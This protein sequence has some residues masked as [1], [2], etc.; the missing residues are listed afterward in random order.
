MKTFKT[1][2]L[3]LLLTLSV[4]ISVLSGSV[5]AEDSTQEALSTSALEG[6][7]ILFLGDSLQTAHGLG[8]YSLSWNGMLESLDGM[9]ATNIAV[10]GSTM[11]E[12]SEGGYAW[13]SGYCHCPISARSLP[14]G[15]FDVVLIDGGANDW[16]NGLPLGSDPVNRD[17]GNF[18][19][20]LNTTLDRVQAAYPNALILYTNPWENY[21]WKNALGKIGDDYSIA[22]ME[23]CT[24][25]NIP[26]LT[27]HLPSVSGIY[28]MDPAFR[29]S[30]FLKDSDYWHLNAAGH[31]LFYP[32]ISGWLEQELLENYLVN[33]FYD[34]PKHEWYA[35]AVSG[36][37]EKGLMVGI[38]ACHFS[39][40]METTRAML[41]SVLYRSAGSPDVSKLDC[42]FSDVPENAYY[43][44]A[45]KW[46]YHNGIVYG[47]TE[48]TFGPSL[49]LSRQQLVAFLY[50]YAGSPELNGYTGIASFADWSTVS[51][52]A[53]DAMCW[54]VENGIVSGTSKNTLSPRSTALR[55]QIAAMLLRYLDKA[56]N[57]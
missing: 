49:S 33:G 40:N 16:Y 19:G 48:D 13:N 44:N 9:I 39:P 45:V 56:S 57:A 2:L 4:V 1:K 28:A 27:S 11:C 29:R 50:R 23:V 14:A 6:K 10:A 37:C 35:E 54:A 5:W 31:A 3:P 24:S 17:T 25:R 22:A 43:Y 15:S 21:N 42:P 41:V 18:M 8:D 53:Q 52:Y 38:D 7:R 47:I 34:V 30:Y 55:S 20:A 36:I 32:V 51:E 12:G 46:G 26:C